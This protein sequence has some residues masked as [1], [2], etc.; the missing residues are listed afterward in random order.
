MTFVVDTT[1]PA[2]VIVSPA[3]GAVSSSGAIIASGDS[4]SAPGNEPV[5]SVEVLAAG[6]PTGTPLEAVQ[7]PLS[8]SGWSATIAGLSPGSYVLR[9]EQRDAAGNVGVSPDV[10][11]SVVPPA[12]PAASFTWFPS[13]PR[14]G[15]PVTLISDST[16]SESAITSFG[17]ALSGTAPF[18][19]G[20]PTMTTTFASPGP[21]TLRLLVADAAGRSDTAKETILVGHAAAGLIEPFPI[22]RIAGRETR[23]G[24][25]LS[26]LTVTAPLSSRVTVKIRLPGGRTSS[27][28]SRVASAST[29]NAGSTV[30]MPFPRFAR[31]LLVG[32]VLE[33]RV[34]KP[35]EIGKLT[36]FVPHRGRLPTRQDSCLG[37]TE[38]PIRCPTQ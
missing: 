32:S 14:V 15:E 8:A 23:S 34:T 2:P 24:V 35:G 31:S 5:V 28:T 6:E 38:Q 16:D 13:T 4:T 9:A 7:A 17:W 1:P 29:P 20:G 12:P 25:R 33:V 22:V 11:F 3:P 19:G 27:Q 26:L 37:L 10:P 21:H 36:R 30:V 18:I